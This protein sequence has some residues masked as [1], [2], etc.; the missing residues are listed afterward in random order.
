MVVSMM[1][2]QCK[3][4]TCWTT[5]HHS[6]L[7]ADCMP[8]KKTDRSSVFGFNHLLDAGPGS[9]PSAVGSHCSDCMDLAIVFLNTLTH[10]NTM[11]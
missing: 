3:G 1:L 4:P 9:G 6:C 2:V 7:N 10:G 8:E 11:I 5:D